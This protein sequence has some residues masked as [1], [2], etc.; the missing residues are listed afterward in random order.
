MKIV[1]VVNYCI[2]KNLC[3]KM[4][5]IILILLSICCVAVYGQSEKGRICFYFIDEYGSVVQPN[6][7]EIIDNEGNSFRLSADYCFDYCSQKAIH[8]II[9]SNNYYECEKIYRTPFPETDTLILREIIKVFDYF[10]FSF[11]L[12]QIS[13]CKH[14]ELSKQFDVDVTI[15]HYIDTITYQDYEGDSLVVKLLV[16]D[17]QNGKLLDSIGIISTFDDL[18]YIWYFKDGYKGIDIDATSYSTGFQIKK[19]I[20]DSYFGNIVV[21]D[22]NFDGKDDIALICGSYVDAGPRYAFFIQNGENKFVKNDFLT[23]EMG[24]FPCKINFKRKQLITISF[25]NA[26]QVCKCVY[27]WNPKTNNWKRISKKYFG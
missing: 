8:I 4:K 14:T 12:N 1:S 26:Y 2:L 7:V 13:Q 10:S 16:K 27:K 9:N 17:K 3:L 23:N 24:F 25:A 20:V 19:E 21:A 11:T 15:E 6:K 22:L 18:G 5:R